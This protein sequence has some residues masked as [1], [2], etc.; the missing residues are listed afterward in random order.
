M[1]TVVYMVTDK[2]TA[3]KVV[4]ALK[5]EGFLVKTKEIMKSKKRGCYIEILVPE[6][7]AEEAQKTILEKNL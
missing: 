3:D 6:S 4:N 1:W 2:E 5:E 7:E